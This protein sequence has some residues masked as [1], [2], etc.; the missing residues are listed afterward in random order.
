MADRG[1]QM[2]TLNDWIESSPERARDYAQERL[3]AEVAEEIW[4]AMEQTRQSKSDIA[5]S[6]GKTKAFVGQVLNGSR[7]MTLRTLADIA[8]T[9]GRKVHI[10]L[11]DPKSHAEWQLMKGDERLEFRRAVLV[12]GTLNVSNGDKWQTL[13]VRAAETPLKVA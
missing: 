8:H 13:E 3:I 7:N 11:F 12:D 4:A 10:E 6:L 9:L 2:S 1:K 5:S